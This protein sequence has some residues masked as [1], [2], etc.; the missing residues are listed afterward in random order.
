MVD[1]VSQCPLLLLRICINAH[2]STSKDIATV[3][4]TSRNSYKCFLEKLLSSIDLL[5]GV[6]NDMSHGDE[7]EGS[8]VYLNGWDTVQQS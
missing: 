2:D 7:T 3:Q 1:T 6:E 5:E 4:V 8:K